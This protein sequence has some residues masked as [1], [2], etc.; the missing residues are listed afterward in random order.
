MRGWI[1]YFGF[2]KQLEN[3][4]IHWLKIKYSINLRVDILIVVT[5]VAPWRLE[6]SEYNNDIR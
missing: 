6:I 2:I 1:I 5:G 3:M 4:P